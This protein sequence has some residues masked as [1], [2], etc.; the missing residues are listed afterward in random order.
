MAIIYTVEDHPN[1]RGKVKES[2]FL[3]LPLVK[4]QRKFG[5]L[6]ITVQECHAFVEPPHTAESMDQTIRKTLAKLV[7]EN[8]NRKEYAE[9]WE[10]LKK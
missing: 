5:F 8:L 6:W 1:L 2:I 7:T 9:A 3:S 10:D 4:L